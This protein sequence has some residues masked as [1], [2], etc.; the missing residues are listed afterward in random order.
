[1]KASLDDIT[2]DF[3]QL[4]TKTQID[5]MANQSGMVRRASCKFDPIAFLDVLV[6]KLAQC[7]TLSLSSMCSSLALHCPQ[8]MTPQALCQRLDS[9]G[10]VRFL[11]GIYSYILNQKLTQSLPSV[12]DRGILER[13]RNVYLEDSTCCPLPEEVAE[14]F[15]GYGG[16]SSSAG[17]KL[18]TMW[19]AS[20]H[21]IKHQH[22]SEARANDSA[23]GRRS[24]QLLEPGDLILRDLAYSN[25]KQFHAI[26][27]KEAY[28]LS[29]YSGNLSVH[30]SDGKPIE[31]L[32]TSICDKMDKGGFVEMEVIIGKED[33]IPV[34][35]VAYRI[36]QKMRKQRLYKMHRGD[37]RRQQKPSRDRQK[38]TEYNI[39]LSNIPRELLEAEE[40]A[41]LYKARWQ[42]ELLFK[43]F[44]STFSLQIIKGKS[45]NRVLS[46][47]FAKLIAITL[48]YI[49]YPR[50]QQYV[51]TEYREELSFAKFTT[52]ISTHSYL[53]ALF[54]LEKLD[55]KVST[56]Q[57]ICLLQLCKQRRS[58]KTTAQLLE[59]AIPFGFL[60]PKNRQINHLSA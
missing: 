54:Q 44:K 40:M 9:E 51:K 13:F 26:A 4:L 37:G 17:F 15:R 48:A 36:P 22:I 45:K 55:Y 47:I 52:W 8:S 43:T 39:F 33:P 58:R 38:L 21:S 60:Y 41:T 35:L 28:F 53:R 59:Q 25:L 5:Q 7:G 24:V 27:S 18:H 1:M 56:M 57:N 46:L 10:T 3:K 2:A 30:H 19:N 20:T 29:R 34:R 50:V 12:I 32:H 14:H 31:C 42:I 23:Q 6:V 49:V 16:S 11:R